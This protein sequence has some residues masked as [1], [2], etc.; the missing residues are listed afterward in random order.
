[1][2][3]SGYIQADETP[4]PV[5][6]REK[7]QKT[8]RGYYWVYLAPTEGLVC[9]EYRSGRGRDG[10][11]NW[12][13]GFEGSLQ[14]DGYAVYDAYDHAPRVTT[15]S[16]WAHA[17]RNFFEAKD[18]APTLAEEALERIKALY[19][20]ERELRETGSDA[21]TRR[22]VRQEQALPQL[23]DLHAWLGAHPGLP[24]SPWGKAVAYAMKR[25]AKLVR[26]T[27]DG[28][29]EIDNNLVENTIRPIALGRRNYLFAGS[30]EGARRGAVIYSLVGT[31]KLHDVN[32]QLW[33]A[34]VLG[35]IPTHPAKRIDELLPHRWEK[36][37]M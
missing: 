19:E 15:Y 33:L 13:D 5:L 37:K 32:P 30:H 21:E 22:R 35:R 4:I 11:T 28:Q 24:Q 25:W 27:E 6:D 23:E 2:K 20:I 7:K 16:C 12:L 26:Y 9:V 36:G 34:D 3:L 1:M 31:C 17:R 29:V 8:H 10:P 18:N 14:S